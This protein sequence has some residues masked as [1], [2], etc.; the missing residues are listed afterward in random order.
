MYWKS[1][2]RELAYKSNDGVIYIDDGDDEQ[3]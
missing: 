1:I 3:V 2:I